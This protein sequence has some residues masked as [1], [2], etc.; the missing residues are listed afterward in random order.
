MRI[1]SLTTSRLPVGLPEWSYRSPERT[2]LEPRAAFVGRVSDPSHGNGER[3]LIR[4]AQREN[5]DDSADNL[6]DRGSPGENAGSERCDAKEDPAD[7]EEP[8]S[9]DG[10]S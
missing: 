5:A 6:Q 7:R 3:N 4:R 9:C 2:T 1:S 10:A 8:E